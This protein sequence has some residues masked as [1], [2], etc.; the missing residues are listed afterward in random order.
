[1]G[2][3]TFNSEQLQNVSNDQQMNGLQ[4]L[5]ASAHHQSVYPRHIAH[6][7]VPE[8]CDGQTGQEYILHPQL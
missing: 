7:L 4:C 2:Y 1:M 3:Y 8:I 6:H 5:L